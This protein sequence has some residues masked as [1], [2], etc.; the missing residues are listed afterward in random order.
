MKK[1]AELSISFV[2]M[3]FAAAVIAE[4]Q[5]P[6]KVFRVGILENVSSPRT[7][8]FR[9]GLRELGYVE[10]QNLVIESRFGS[11]DRL[12]DLA[13]ELVRLKVDVIFAPMTN[14]LQAAENAT[15]TIPI[16]MATPSDP[17]GSGFIASLA[18]PGGNVTGLTSIFGDL[19]AKRLELFKEAVPKITR[20]AVLADPAIPNYAA[21]VK[22]LEE[23]AGS[24]RLKLQILEVRHPGD[25]DT[26][27]SAISRDRVEALFM[28]PAPVFFAESRR[29]A[30]FSSKRRLP[31]SC[32]SGEYAEVGCLMSYGVSQ[33][34]SFRRAAYFVDKILKGAKPG[35]LPVQQ[36]MK[37]EL[38][39]NLRTA[40]QIGVTIPQSVLYRADRV[41]K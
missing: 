6:K 38:V 14:E 11:D 23:T 16:V 10:G 17:I 25:L 7:D 12:P 21:V 34:D 26:A 9:Q 36:P 15:R 28:A 31:S 29:I 20:V 4:A 8:A 32:A 41:I 22:G 18:H 24:L 1:A 37:F 19:S 13:D 30:D 3:L 27:F 33:T 35:D 40:N 5:Q 2:V 39:I